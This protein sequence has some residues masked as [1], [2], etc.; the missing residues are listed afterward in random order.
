MAEV[1]NG[2]LQVCART[3]VGYGLSVTPG[4]KLGVGDVAGANTGL[5]SGTTATTAPPT[6]PRRVPSDSAMPQKPEPPS[7]P[8]PSR[9]SVAAR[10]TQATPARPGPSRSG[11]GPVIVPVRQIP[12]A[13]GSASAGNDS[14]KPSCVPVLLFTQTFIHKFSFQAG[15]SMDAA[16]GT[17]DRGAHS[18]EFDGGGVVHRYSADAGVAGDDDD[19]QGQALVVRHS[20]R[21]ACAA[22]G[23]RF[24][25]VVGCG[26]GACASGDG[27]AGT[28]AGGR[29]T[30]GDSSGEQRE[31]WQDED[32]EAQG[33][34]TTN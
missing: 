30:Y 34:A 29:C 13:S 5:S 11:M 23:G 1:G 7:T 26:R 22:A 8:T 33:R 12:S 28:G 16:A 9:T 6:T 24:L 3:V 17:A 31:G 4:T 27:G 20:G 2:K 21:G 18:T 32:W 19:T 14:W 25:E 10:G 15:S